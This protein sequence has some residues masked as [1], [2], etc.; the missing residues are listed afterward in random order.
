MGQMVASGKKQPIKT[1]ARA[2]T[3]T[4]DMVGW[5]FQVHNGRQFIEVLVN[6]NMVGHRLGEFALTRKFIKHGGKM[7][8]EQ[9]RA[10][11]EAAKPPAATAPAAKK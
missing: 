1:W 8:K 11:A 2:S 3:I 9:E 6:E 7:Q 5:K 4:P 10:A